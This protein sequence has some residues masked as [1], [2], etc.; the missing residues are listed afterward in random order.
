MGF[1]QLIFW[2]IVTVV[3]FVAA[4]HADQCIHFTGTETMIS[5]TRKNKGGQPGELMSQ[6]QSTRSLSEGNHS[7]WCL[8]DESI[9]YVEAGNGPLIKVRYPFSGGFVDKT[10]KS[11]GLPV[12]IT[13]IA[14]KTDNVVTVNWLY[15]IGDKLSRGQA[16]N[17]AT[18]VELSFSFEISGRTCKLNAHKW[19]YVS[20]TGSKG[21]IYTGK[22]TLSSANAT[23]AVS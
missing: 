17:M 19:T 3:P 12:V 10:I 8:D 13:G 5:E 18:R 21:G 15:T 14:K 7:R 9:T 16:T 11:S 2:I 22:R 6:S 1:L 4:A 23:C 20:N